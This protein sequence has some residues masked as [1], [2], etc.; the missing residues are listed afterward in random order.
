MSTNLFNDY[1]NLDNLNVPYSQPQSQLLN[2]EIPLVYGAKLVDG[3]IVSIKYNDPTVAGYDS[4]IPTGLCVIYALARGECQELRNF[5]LDGVE[6]GAS[7]IKTNNVISS[8]SSSAGGGNFYVS[9]CWTSGDGSGQQNPIAK[10]MRI[11]T[12]GLSNICHIALFFE[13]Q[14]SFKELP[15]LTAYLLGKKCRDYSSSLIS[16]SSNPVTVISDL[17]QDSNIG[18]GYALSN[19]DATSFGTAASSLGATRSNQTPSQ[20][21]W[22]CNVAY[23]L[24][25]GVNRLIETICQTYLLTLTFENNKFFITAEQSPVTTGLTID[26]NIILGDVTVLYPGIRYKYNKVAVNYRNPLYLDAVSTISWPDMSLTNTN[27]Y[28][29][30]DGNIPI[31]VTLSAE[32]IT[33]PRQAS[34]LAQMMLLRSRNQRQYQFRASRAMHQFKIG[35]KVTLNVQTPYISNQTVFITEMTLLEDYTFQVTCVTWSSS[36]YPNSFSNQVD[37]PKP[38]DQVIPGQIG[39]TYSIGSGSG[40]PPPF[41][42][43]TPISQTWSIVAPTKMNEG[44]TKTFVVNSIGIS[45]GTVIKFDITPLNSSQPATSS[46]FS[47]STSGTLTINSNTASLT[48]TSVGDSSTEGDEIYNFNIRS[49]ST[50]QL[51]ASHTFTL[52]DTSLAQ[53]STSFAFTTTNTAQFITNTNNTWYCGYVVKNGANYQYQDLYNNS[54]GFLTTIKMGEVDNRKWLELWLW[55]FITDRDSKTYN[56]ERN[57]FCLPSIGTVSNNVLV[58]SYGNKTFS[59]YKWLPDQQDGITKFT[60][61]YQSGGTVADT[62]IYPGQRLDRTQHGNSGVWNYNNFTRPIRIPLRFGNSGAAFNN[63][64]YPGTNRIPLGQYIHDFS[65]SILTALTV[66]VFFY[67]ALNAPGTYQVRDIGYKDYVINFNTGS[68]HQ[69]ISTAYLSEAR[70]YYEYVQGGIAPF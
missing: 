67:E 27:A 19:I 59:T 52:V 64:A 6:F 50:G 70:G 5:Y 30:E 17:L 48:V 22:D 34:D 47:T 23:N 55:V 57:I 54:S 16:W 32:T 15:N 65:V 35:D 66:R 2:S 21:I 68:G 45:N 4:T 58:H 42:N 14:G 63:Y 26:E 29:V 31:E 56:T 33:N 53:P 7:A 25:D 61:I 43:P 62:T 24:S 37:M 41:V 46:D 28:L 39:I 36:F 13:R 10:S 11:D 51:L 8:A 38:S 12:S 69:S 40:T 1:L 60:A 44:E 9:F 3:G 18:K 49:S 20:P